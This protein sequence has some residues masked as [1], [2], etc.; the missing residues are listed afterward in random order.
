MTFLKNSVTFP[1]LLIF[2]KK[3]IIFLHKKMKKYKLQIFLI[4]NFIIE[5]RKHCGCL[6]HVSKTART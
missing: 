2:F 1:D 6:M 5:I 3:I 4:I